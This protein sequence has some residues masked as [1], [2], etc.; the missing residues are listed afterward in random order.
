M[1]AEYAGVVALPVR[2][3]FEAMTRRH[4]RLNER[5]VE[6][7]EDTGWQALTLQNG[8]VNYGG[9]FE[10]AGVRRHGK[11]VSL[12]GLVKSGV[13]GLVATLPS[14]FAPAQDFIFATSSGNAFGDVYVY[15]NGNVNIQTAPS[16]LFVSLHT[17]W[18]V[19]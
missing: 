18:M 5:V 3:A 14:G 6:L 1:R 12:R 8:W 2:R 11:V 9:T 13:V 15:A 7:E 10:T 19:G 17:S 4:N 16:N